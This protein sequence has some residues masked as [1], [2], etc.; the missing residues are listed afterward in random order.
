LSSDQ[1]VVR[2][3]LSFSGVLSLVC[4]QNG[5][6]LRVNSLCWPLPHLKPSFWI[7]PHSRMGSRWTNW[8]SLNTDSATWLQPVK[9][10]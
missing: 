4:P 2:R 9:G 7:L 5:L 6:F 8:L 1:E 10:Q 3:V